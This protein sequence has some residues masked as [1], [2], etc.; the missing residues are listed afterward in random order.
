MV[1]P[2]VYCTRENKTIAKITT[3]TV[4]SVNICVRSDLFFVVFDTVKSG[5]TTNGFHNQHPRSIDV[6]RTIFRPDFE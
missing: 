4:Y 6:E 1:F 2:G 5:M 3:Y